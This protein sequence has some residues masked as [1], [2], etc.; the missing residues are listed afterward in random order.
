MNIRHFISNFEDQTTR[1]IYFDFYVKRGDTS[2]NRIKEAKNM[3]FRDRMSNHDFWPNFFRLTISSIAYEMF[4]LIKCMIQQSNFEKAK[5]WMMDNIRLFLLKIGGTIK[6]TKR[7]IYVNLSKH[8]VYKDLFLS[9]V[10][11]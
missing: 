6:K 7:R 9:L 3:Y 5:K 1:E 10:L 2:E 8:V 4:R 11:S